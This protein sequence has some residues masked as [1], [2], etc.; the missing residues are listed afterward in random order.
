VHD[1]ATREFV[2]IGVALYASKGSFLKARCTTRYGRAA[3]LFGQNVDG[4]AFRR[5]TR[6]VEREIN[7]LGEKLGSD[8][9]LAGDHIA[10]VLD[11]V[12]P[13]D[14][15]AIQFSQAGA[16]L[17]GDLDRTLSELYERF[18]ERYEKHE[19]ER[20]TEEDVWRVFRDPLARKNV[21]Q[22]LQPKK[23]IAPSIEYEFQHTWKNTRW[24][25][26]E[27]ISFDLVDPQYISEKAARWVGRM[28][29]LHEAR[30]KLELHFLLGAP[31]EVSLQEAFA[32]AQNLMHK[33]PGKH[34]FYQES[35]AEALAQQLS[36]EILEHQES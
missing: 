23:V 4:K 11:R 16:G 30:E 17:S 18:V 14:D 12:L 32:K 33:M 31:Q 25:A 5:L 20:R 1:A 26:L 2:N 21:I 22:H 13:R 9:P 15:S 34:A 10:M 6:F 28:T 7:R 36:E 19:R 3:A 35:E 24:H 8:L 29:G 27:P